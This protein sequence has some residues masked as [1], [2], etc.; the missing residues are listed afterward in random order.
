MKVD[1]PYA[2]IALII[3]AFTNV[4]MIIYL[5]KDKKKNQL[6]KV[7]KYAVELLLIWCIGMILQITL[8]DKLNIQK[9]YFDYFVYI[10]ICFVPITVFFLGLI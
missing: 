2:L 1:N 3:T 6:M 8:S 4:V 9:I 7:F 10:P 5:N